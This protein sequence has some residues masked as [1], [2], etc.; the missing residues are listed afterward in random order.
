MG[1]QQG[2]SPVGIGEKPSVSVQHFVLK[3]KIWI[4]QPMAL[5]SLACFRFLLLLLE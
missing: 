4:E 1:H 2:R 3:S 5:R